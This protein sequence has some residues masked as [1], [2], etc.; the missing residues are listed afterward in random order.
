MLEKEIAEIPI[1]MQ[2]HEVITMDDENGGLILTEDYGNQTTK[3]IV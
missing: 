2:A 3:E 1:D